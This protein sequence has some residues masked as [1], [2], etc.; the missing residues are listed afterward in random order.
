MDIMLI[1]NNYFK[2][3]IHILLIPLKEAYILKL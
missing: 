2:N 1:N 3:Y